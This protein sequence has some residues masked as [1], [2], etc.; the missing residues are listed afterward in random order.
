MKS[1]VGKEINV[2]LER[3][4]W[5]VLCIRIRIWPDPKLFASKDPDP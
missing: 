3:R 1:R 4:R 5:A 2:I